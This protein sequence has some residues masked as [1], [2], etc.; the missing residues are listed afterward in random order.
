MR[1]PVCKTECNNNS[2]CPQ[3]GFSEVG[4]LFVN[5]GDAE[6]WYSSVVV[7]FKHDYEKGHIMPPLDWAEVFKQE[8]HSKA[9]F[10]TSIPAALKKQVDLT[11]FSPDDPMFTS[12]LIDAALGHILLKSINELVDRHFVAEISKAMGQS[13]EVKTV[14]LNSSLWPGDLAAVLTTLMPF[15]LV[16][17]CVTGK[18]K[19]ETIEILQQALDQF[20]IHVPLGKGPSAKSIQLDLPVFTAIFIVKKIDNIPS[21]FVDT[22]SLI[23]EPNFS[24][25]ELLE[26]QI[27][28][29]SAKHEVALT[30]ETLDILKKHLQ[31][32]SVKQAL[33]LIADYLFLHQE[34]KQPISG[35]EMRQ[36]LENS[37]Q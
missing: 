8:L 13:G 4:K 22:I 35:D 19:Q 16:V 32:A 7:P 34:I 33:R 23:I 25:E 9:L 31:T 26:Y 5:Q 14:T 30:R 37:C 27:R 15:S 2:N 12:K 3:C 24:K 21:D 17:F 11:N 20:A 36:I 1:C 18:M 10:E 6:Q 28:E 29:I